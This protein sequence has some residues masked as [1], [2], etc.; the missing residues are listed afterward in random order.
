MV[1]ALCWRCV[2]VL[3]CSYLYLGKLI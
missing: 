2:V 3:I 1:L